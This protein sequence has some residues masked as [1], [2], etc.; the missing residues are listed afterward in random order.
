MGIL[1]GDVAGEGWRKGPRTGPGWTSGRIV[2]VAC[3]HWTASDVAVIV[4]GIVHGTLSEGDRVRIVRTEKSALLYLK[5]QV[6]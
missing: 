3:A 6:V 2:T 4:A 1:L 5:P